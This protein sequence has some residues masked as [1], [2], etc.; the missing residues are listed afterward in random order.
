MKRT[1][2]GKDEM[3]RAYAGLEKEAPAWMARHIRWLH[4]PASRKF[5]LPIGILLIACGLVG[6]LPIVG[7]EFIPVGLLV[8]SQDIPFLRRPMG[9]F[10]LWL[11]EKW[12][13]LKKRWKHRHSHQH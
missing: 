4:S 9:K 6:F 2:T 7:Y 1:K 5:R 12:K 3:D 10:V 11:L 8:I 13:V